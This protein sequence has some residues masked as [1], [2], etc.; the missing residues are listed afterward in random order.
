MK[1][2]SVNELTESV[3]SNL[4]REIKS[5]I[6]KNILAEEKNPESVREIFTEL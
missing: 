4:P 1:P 5:T 2:I 3:N 6:A